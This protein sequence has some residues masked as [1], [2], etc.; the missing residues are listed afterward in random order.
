MRKGRAGAIKG[1]F[2]TAKRNN[3]DV[4]HDLAPLSGVVRN[5]RHN[6]S[7]SLFQ[8]AHSILTASMLGFGVVSASPFRQN[9]K[10]GPLC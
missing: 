10:I 8:G 4:Q 1:G 6:E 5:Q 2:G 7:K 9:L 3:D